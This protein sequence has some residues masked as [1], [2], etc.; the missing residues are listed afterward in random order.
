MA[1][2]KGSDGTVHVGTDAVAEIR[3]WSLEST[4]DTIEDSVMGDS[5]RTYQVGL[6]SWSASVDCY[7]DDDDTAQTAL[8][9]GAS[10]SLTLYPEGTSAGT[11]YT[12]TALVTS[13]STSS[14]FDG[15]LEVSFSCTG[16]GALT[17]ATI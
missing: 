8:T 4:A 3:S 16:T 1:N 9:A 17:T 10:V 11:K 6:A 7:W 5:A 15:M 13:V 12:G 14:S 2:H